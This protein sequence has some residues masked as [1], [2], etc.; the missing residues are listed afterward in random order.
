MKILGKPA[1]T[2]VGTSSL[3]LR[4][5]GHQLLDVFPDCRAQ[6]RQ[7][8]AALQTRHYPA[9]ANLGGPLA[10][11]TGHADEIGV[12]KE[13]LSEWISAMRVETCLDDD[14]VGRHFR[15]DIG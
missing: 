10:S 3:R 1:I 5:Q 2:K 9:L 11:R 15:R 14:E 8:V 7:V 12:L 6:R 4:T 13:Q